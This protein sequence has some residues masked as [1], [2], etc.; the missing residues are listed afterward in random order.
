MPMAAPTRSNP[1]SS[2]AICITLP[3]SNGVASANCIPTSE[4]T[5]A[6][7][8]K[9]TACEAA[10]LILPSRSNATIHGRRMEKSAMRICNMR[11][12]FTVATPNR[13]WAYYDPIANPPIK[14]VTI[15]PTT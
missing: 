9:R 14:T 12:C 4:A 6:V 2:D 7:S 1:Y 11:N 5:R 15:S 3:F 13:R 8:K 10:G